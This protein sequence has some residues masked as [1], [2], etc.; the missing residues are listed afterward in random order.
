M[1]VS[2]EQIKGGLEKLA[3]RVDTWPPNAIEFRQLCMP[4]TVSPDG[5]N[6][7]A[8]LTFDDEKHPEYKHYSKAKRIEN[9]TTVSQRKETGNNELKNL[10]DLF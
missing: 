8:Y 5:L 10:K 9:S 7:A 4:E 6:S 3:T 2:P 1:E